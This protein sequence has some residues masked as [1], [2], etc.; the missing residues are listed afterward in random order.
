MDK[1]VYT[2]DVHWTHVEEA[3]MARAL[4]E[5]T[6]EQQLQNQATPSSVQHATRCTRCGGLMVTDFSMDLLFCIGETEFAATRCVQC[7]EVIDPVILENRGTRQKPTV[8]Q[9]A[10]RMTS[11]DHVTTDR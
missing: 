5:R 1:I 7:G 11:N 9:L 2:L 3:I 10:E 6:A 8:V 4:G